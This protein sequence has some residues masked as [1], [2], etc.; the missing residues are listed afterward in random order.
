MLSLQFGAPGTDLDL[1]E[2]RRTYVQSWTF[3]PRGVLQVAQLAAVPP[4]TA[5]VPEQASLKL[6]L[7][8][9]H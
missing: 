7:L 4:M 8:A 2:A 9:T 1:G 6:P 3:C 5:G